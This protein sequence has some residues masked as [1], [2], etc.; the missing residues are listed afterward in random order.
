MKKRFIENGGQAKKITF[1]KT[2]QMPGETKLPGICLSTFLIGIFAGVL[3]AN[4]S[5]EGTALWIGFVLENQAR[6]FVS[7]KQSVGGFFRFALAPRIIPFGILVLCSYFAWGGVLLACWTG[8]LGL[9][10]GFLLSALILRYGLSGIG[11]LILMICP[12]CLI[13]GLAYVLLMKNLNTFNKESERKMI[14]VILSIFIY[15]IS[16]MIEYCFTPL[17]LEM[18]KNMC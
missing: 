15:A 10:G 1:K 6:Q 17:A 5:L 9:G 7:P 14:F 3:L 8:W 16:I 18:Y 12:Q 2:G 4:T 13:Y 11:Y